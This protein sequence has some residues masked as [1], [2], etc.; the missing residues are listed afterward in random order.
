MDGNVEWS[1]WH[2]YQK[3][4]AIGRVCGK[5]TSRYQED[6]AHVVIRLPSHAARTLTLTVKAALSDP[7]VDESFGISNI[8]ISAIQPGWPEIA[9]FADGHTH[10]WKGD[11]AVVS[12]CGKQGTILG[13]AGN[14]VALTAMSRGALRLVFGM[15]M[16]GGDGYFSILL[17]RCFTP[18]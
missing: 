9:T 16:K 15:V 4:T 2:S 13:G 3:T 18:S 12:T 7:G 8:R 1:A 5:S 6:V 17:G 11:A 14:G 10:G